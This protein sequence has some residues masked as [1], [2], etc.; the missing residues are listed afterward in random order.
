MVRLNEFSLLRRRDAANGGHYFLTHSQFLTFTDIELG[1]LGA[2][3]DEDNGG[4]HLEPSNGLSLVE[5]HS[6]FLL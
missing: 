4:S 5:V 6:V 2:F 1:I 3:K